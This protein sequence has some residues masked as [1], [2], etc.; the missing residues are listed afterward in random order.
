MS[1]ENVRLIRSAIDEF[2]ETRRFGPAF[3]ACVHPKV[4][5]QDEIGAYE[6]RDEVRDFLEGFADAIGGLR[7]DVQETR[8]LGD[9]VLVVVR[10]S[11]QGSASTAFVE[12]PFTW[13]LRFEDG[14][15]VRWRIWA[16]HEKALEDAGLEE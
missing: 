11:G 12:Q 8:D 15:C 9:T 4:S 7:V 5:F 13:V 6:S 1:Q 10:Q 3:E 16:D 2:N 14:R